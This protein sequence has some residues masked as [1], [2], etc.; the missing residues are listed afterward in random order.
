M[1]LFAVSSVILI[2]MRLLIVTQKAD[3][4]DPILGFFHRWLL[5]FSKKCEKLTVVC[6]YE[7]EHDLPAGVKVLS[8]GKEKGVSSL[9]YLINFYKYIWQE[10]N[11]YDAVFVHMNPVYVALGAIPWKIWGKKI[12]LWYVHKS[13]DFKLR[14]AEFFSDDIFTVAKESFQ[15]E[16]GKV[17]IVG[18]GIP[19]ERFSRPSDE[20]RND[21]KFRIISVGRI[22]PIKNLDTLIEAAKIVKE[23][24]NNIDL[25]ILLVGGPA[26][27]GDE[28]YFE[29]LKKMTAEF[30]LEKNVVFLGNVPND[31]IR[32][33]YWKSDL[34]VNLCPTGGVDKAVLESMASGLPVLASNKAFEAYFG[35]YK[36]V[37]MFGLRDPKDLAD[38]ILKIIEGDNGKEIKEFLLRSVAE[39]ASLENL[40]SKIISTLQVK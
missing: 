1:F 28:K 37:L 5:E 16:S 17:H 23:E 10:R 29:K 21:N 2:D 6:L 36:G 34:S 9:E 32:K 39:R 7:G 31:E 35:K 3:K 26:Q 25:E 13:V 38:R 11:N 19:V 18:H 40:I 33:Y 12:S 22:T 24:K 20:K 14:V 8:L 15:L 4:N 27:K 30:G